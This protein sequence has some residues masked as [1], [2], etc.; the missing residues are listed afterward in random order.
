MGRLACALVIGFVSSRLDRKGPW[1]PL[2][3]LCQMKKALL[4][5]AA[6]AAT[7]FGACVGASAEEGMWTF[8]NT[9]AAAIRETHGFAPDQDWLD[10]VRLG[11]CG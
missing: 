9:P 1:G 4:A 10:R 8:D 11:P 6:L 3:D 7:A 5:A 2:G